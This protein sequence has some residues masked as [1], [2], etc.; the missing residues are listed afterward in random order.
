LSEPGKV[1]VKHDVTL[2][3]YT[4]IAGRLA[5]VASSLYAK[6]VVNFLANLWDEESKSLKTDSDDEI[7]T[8][9]L[10]TKPVK[11]AK[12]AQASTKKASTKKEGDKDGE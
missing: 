3:G 6:N 4:N 9:S 11:A 10:I 5:E 12:P 1:V 7:I 8:S 2:V